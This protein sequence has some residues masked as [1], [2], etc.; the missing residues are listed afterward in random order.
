[1]DGYIY[2]CIL[3]YIYVYICILVYPF[4]EGAPHRSPDPH[5]PTQTPCQKQCP[6][7]RTHLRWQ[8]WWARC[9]CRPMW[10][11]LVVTSRHPWLTHG[12]L[13]CPTPDATHSLGASQ[14]TIS[15]MV[16][17]T[18]NKRRA[19]NFEAI[20]ESMRNDLTKNMDM[21]GFMGAT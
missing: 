21:I 10:A 15:C 18:S 2:I 1:M 13:H 11:G 3:R 19:T 8:H 16:N 7:R 9:M 12:V 17:Q 14:H 6:H 4:N 5:Q 20:M